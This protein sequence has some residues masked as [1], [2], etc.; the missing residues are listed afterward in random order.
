MKKTETKKSIIKTVTPTLLYA[1]AAFF[2]LF[3]VWGAAYALVGNPYL[4]P[5]LKDTFSSLM[6]LLKEKG[7]YTAYLQTFSRVLQAFIISFL[8]ALILA[9]AAYLSAPVRKIAAVFVSAFR[10]I[11]TMAILLMILVWSTPKEAPV[12][13]AFLALF[14]LLYT[15]VLSSL[16]AVDERYKS[17]F[18]TFR[19][20]IRKRIFRAYLPLIFPSVLR[21][22]AGALSF[23]LKLVVSA[24]IMANTFKSIGGLM[25]D[26]K[27]YLDMPRLFALT[28]MV[29]ITGLLLETLGN[30]IAFAA[31]RR[32]K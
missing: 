3:A 24:E 20:P 16:F 2:A 12:I 5:S 28:L 14:P 30:L 10:S 25:Q 6:A 18:E 9:V 26:S 29:V 22:S 27:I 8:P 1:A 15:G 23:S 7:F 19:I 21:E 32:T 31:E 17:V 4:V 11:P 13:V